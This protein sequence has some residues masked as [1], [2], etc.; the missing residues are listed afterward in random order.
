MNLNDQLKLEKT[1]MTQNQLN[2]L[3]SFLVERMVD[4]MSTEDLVAY[5][6]DDLDKY[7]DDMSDV[8]FIDEAK[9]Y[10]DDGYD[11]VVEEIKEYTDCDFKKNRR[12]NV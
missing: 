9:N 10:W 8:E 12:E 2:E 6:M 11:E 7:Y 5:V 1:G 4:N 3:K